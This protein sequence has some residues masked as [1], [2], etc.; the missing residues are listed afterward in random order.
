MSDLTVFLRKEGLGPALNAVEGVEASIKSVIAASPAAANAEV[1]AI[2]D[3]GTAIETAVLGVIGRA[4]PGATA[5]A[6]AILTPLIQ[7]VEA[8]AEKILGAGTTT[9]PA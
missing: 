9:P 4:F 6:P 2:E 3:V 1:V 7:S 5:L 8:V